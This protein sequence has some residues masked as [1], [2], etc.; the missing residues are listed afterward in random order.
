MTHIPNGMFR[1]HL[2]RYDFTLIDS[3]H[4]PD[5]SMV[6]VWTASTAGLPETEVTIGEVAKS[7]G[8]Q[9][10][11]IGKWHLGLNCPGKPNCHSPINQV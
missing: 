2:L 6:I 3:T 11:Y 9:T 1:K 10:G 7:A 5:G 8:Y 4:I